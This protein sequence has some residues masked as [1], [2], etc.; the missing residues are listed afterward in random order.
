[1]TTGTICHKCHSEEVLSDGSRRCSPCYHKG[2]TS[3][4]VPTVLGPMML[5]SQNRPRN[6]NKLSGEQ[7]REIDKSLG[8][9]DWDGDPRS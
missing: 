3:V 9:L 2:I 1:V 8:I 6:Y 5:A 4:S 7:Q